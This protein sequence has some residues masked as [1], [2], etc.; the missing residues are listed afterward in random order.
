MSDSLKE[1]AN[2]LNKLIETLKDGQ[3]GFEVASEDVERVDLK[4][5]FRELSDQRGTFATELQRFVVLTGNEPQDEGTF[6]GTLHRWWISLKA[7]WATRDDIAIL[8]EC[9]RGESVAIKAYLNALNMELGESRPKVVEQ[10]AV[11]K[12]SHDRIVSMKR[13]LKNEQAAYS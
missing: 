9:E 13:S 10:A 2:H 12:D 3:K 11:I 1:T 5:I 7:S 8:E 6:A 4:A